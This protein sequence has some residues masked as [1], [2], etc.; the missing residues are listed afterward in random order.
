VG[1]PR[2]GTQT[3]QRWF[4][5]S[6]FRAP[7]P[8]RFGDAPR[9]GLRGGSLQTVDL[10][11]SKEFVVTERV[12]AEIR[13]EFYNLLNHANFDLPG[14]T[15]GGADFGTVLSARAARTVQLGLRLSF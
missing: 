5:T 4:N 13:G 10:T 7:Q 1:D 15:L 6:A 2:A 14:R 8:F 12:R 3:L 11:A 9:N